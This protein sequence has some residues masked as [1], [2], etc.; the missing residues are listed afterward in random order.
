MNLLIFIYY[1]HWAQH[2]QI[3]DSVEGQLGLNEGADEGARRL[4]IAG[5][6]E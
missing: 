2:E 3:G 1:L 4:Y 5:E 6:P